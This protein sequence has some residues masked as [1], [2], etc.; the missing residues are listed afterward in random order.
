MAE[1]RMRMWL[2]I[3]R[4]TEKH[5]AL[6]RTER[7]NLNR[8]YI[9]RHEPKESIRLKAFSDCLNYSLAQDKDRNRSYWDLCLRWEAKDFS[10]ERIG[11]P[12]V[13]NLV[14][15]ALRQHRLWNEQQNE[16]ARRLAERAA[17]FE[18]QYW[19][20]WQARSIWQ[21]LGLMK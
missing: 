7:T 6:W 16:L 11:H 4:V 10:G 8:E 19:K 1:G 12:P 15:P 20:Q 14:S 5:G 21:A 13:S 2:A 3:H 17:R 9:W 18:Q